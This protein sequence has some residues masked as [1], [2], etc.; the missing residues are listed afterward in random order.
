MSVEVVNESGVAVDE[1][2]LAALSRH[3]LDRMGVHP[4]ADL[5]VRLVDPESME[6][7][8]VRWMD[9]PGPTDVMAF[10]MDELGDPGPGGPD[11]DGPPVLLGDVV[12]CPQVAQRQAQQARHPTEHELAV[13]CTHG[14]LHILGFDHADPDT[15]KE[16]FG[17][18]DELVAGW[19]RD[20]QRRP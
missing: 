9:E 11:E 1:A 3:V 10:P 19:R 8:H 5:A 18:Q 16:M 20:R 2:A 12:I 4:L 13:L 6:A 14:I 7:L 15:E 17:L